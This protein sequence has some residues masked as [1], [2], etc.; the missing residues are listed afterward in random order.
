MRDINRRLLTDALARW[1]RALKGVEGRWQ[2]AAP[3][4]TGVA[5][6]IVE[7]P[8][9]A[10]W[11]NHPHNI[12]DLIA[13]LDATD[14]LPNDPIP[15][16]LEILEKPWH[17]DIEYAQMRGDVDRRDTDPSIATVCELGQVKP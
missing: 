10:H 3:Y 8:L 16:I 13:W 15:G 1:D 14:R 17:W 11:S 9:E 5:K 12:A 2:D 6:A 7:E 4:V